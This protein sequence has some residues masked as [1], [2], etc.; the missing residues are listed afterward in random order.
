MARRVA[1]EWDEEK[2]RLNQEK[3]GVS[4]QEARKAFEDQNR[5]II[6]DLEH[7]QSED[8]YFCLN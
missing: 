5:V 8:R 1:F 6:E 2:D 3:H 4:F 7:S